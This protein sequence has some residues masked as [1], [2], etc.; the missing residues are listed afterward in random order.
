LIYWTSNHVPI[1]SSNNSLNVSGVVLLEN[2]WYYQDVRKKGTLTVVGLFLIKNEYPYE[3]ES[4]INQFDADFNFNIKAEI[5]QISDLYDVN[6]VSGKFLFSINP[7]KEFQ[8]SV[9]AQLLVF[10][11]FVLGVFLLVTSI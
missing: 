2:G 3:N 6:S 5:K 10:G 11:L 7:V 9:W 1:T 8:K 4:L